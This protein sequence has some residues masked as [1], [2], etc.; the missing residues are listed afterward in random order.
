MFACG[1]VDLMRKLNSLIV[2]EFN[3]SF[4]NLSIKHMEKYNIWI[5]LLN[6]SYVIWLFNTTRD[7]F[8]TYL[9]YKFS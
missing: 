1:F 7:S 9:K 5:C 4:V 6:I 8:E 2:G 3:R